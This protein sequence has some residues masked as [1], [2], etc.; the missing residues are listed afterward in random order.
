MDITTTPTSVHGETIDLHWSSAAAEPRIW[1]RIQGG[2]SIDPRDPKR[3]ARLP[4]TNATL[5]N[6]HQARVLAAALIDLAD[7]MDEESRANGDAYLGV[8]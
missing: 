3:L 5:L 7:E 1:L 6:A 8:D 2:E 4:L